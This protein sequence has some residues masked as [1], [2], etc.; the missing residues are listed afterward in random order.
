MA[1]VTDCSRPNSSL[2]L[3]NILD[4]PEHD[5]LRRLTTLVERLFQVPVAYM[6]LLGARN[7]VVTRI[8]NGAEYA[9][10]LHGARPGKLLEEPQ[11]VRDCRLDLPPG[12]D[13]ADLRFAASALLRS[14]SGV[15]FGVLVIAHRQPKPDFSAEDFRTLSDLAAVLAGKIELRLIASLALESEL[16][17]Y[18]IEKRDRG[19]VHCAPVPL[20]YRR[21]DGVCQFVNQAW[22]DFSGRTLEEELAG[23]WD[24]LI[25]PAYRKAVMEEYWRSFETL[26]SF[27]VEAPLRRSDGQ[28]RSMLCK[29]APRFREDGSF[30]GYV[31]CL[32][33]T[34][35]GGTPPLG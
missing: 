29:G 4:E 32:I 24:S 10:V 2:Y 17:L 1:I 19:I 5:G 8:G 27:T 9:S 14:T 15:Q 34:G 23:G 22:L 6:A 31:G 3:Q 25:H 35:D 21:A 13:F 20:L 7:S 33:D 30:A 26:R 12:T 18:D 11:L 16:F 28:Y